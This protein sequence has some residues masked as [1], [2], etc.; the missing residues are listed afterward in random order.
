ME[1]TGSKFA[2]TD[3]LDPKRKIKQAAL[4]YCFITFVEEDDKCEVREKRIRMLERQKVVDENLFRTAHI[5]A[6]HGVITQALL[7]YKAS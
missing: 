4:N 2:V 5:L 1:V 6:H 3:S 7:S